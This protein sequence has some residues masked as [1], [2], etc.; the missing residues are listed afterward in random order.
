MNVIHW[1]ESHSFLDGNFFGL[2]C[3]PSLQFTWS[4]LLGIYIEDTY[5]IYGYIS[6]ISGENC[7][8]TIGSNEH[9]HAQ[10]IRLR[11]LNSL[12]QVT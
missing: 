6:K 11:D 7:R 12:V 8:T 2:Q 10:I 5:L 3:P 9:P 4:T 1:N